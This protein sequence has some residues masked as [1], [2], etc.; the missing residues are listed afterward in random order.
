MKSAVMLLVAMVLFAS[1]VAQAQT[2]TPMPQ[3]D[4]ATVK[5]FEEK[6][7]AMHN[8]F[9]AKHGAPPLTWDT[10]IAAYAK[11]RA[12]YISQHYA[13]SAGHAG[14]EGYGENLHWSGGS[15][16]VFPKGGAAAESAV[17]SWYNEVGRYNF[18]KPGFA[19]GTGHFTQLVWKAST[20]LGCAIVQGKA[21]QRW[22]TYVVCNYSPP[23]NYQGQFPANVL[24][25]K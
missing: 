13:L 7:L 2:R 25:P 6:V 19:S 21:T 14:L 23:G 9:R 17:K 16:A 20:R 10:T 4:A 8:A 18:A 1:V 24:P 3:P 15:S 22:E 11:R 5:A 12:A